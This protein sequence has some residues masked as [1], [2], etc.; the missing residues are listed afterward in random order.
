MRDNVEI[1]RAR[2]SGIR[3]LIDKAGIALKIVAAD[4]GIPYETLLTYFPKEGSSRE[5]VQIP[6]GAVYALCGALPAELLSLLLPDGFQIVRAPEGI[7][8]DEVC[9]WAEGYIASKTKAHRS[10][11]PMGP[12]IAPCEQEELD[13]KVA[14]LPLRVAA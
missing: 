10:D 4:S 13:S 1:I 5:I 12:Q 8:H 9:A 7:D 14:A 11:S 3:R 6:G 2:Q